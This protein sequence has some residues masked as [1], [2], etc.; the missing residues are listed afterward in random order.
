MWVAKA[1]K[2]AS[3]YRPTRARAREGDNSRRSRSFR[4]SCSVRHRPAGRQHL[5]ARS[6][7]RRRTW[8][9]PAA[10]LTRTT[11]E[12]TIM[13]GS[14]LRAG[15]SEARA[16]SAPVAA[17]AA[18]DPAGSAVLALDLGQKTGWAVRNAD[19]AIASGTV[20]F[21]PSRWE[22]GGMVYLRFRA[23][24][25]DDD[26]TAGGIGAVYFEE[27]G[28]PPRHCREPCLRWLP[29]SPDRLGRGRQDP[30]P[31]RA[32]RHDQEACDRPRQRRQDGGHRGGSGTRL[33]PSRRQRGGRA[34][35][36]RRALRN[37]GRR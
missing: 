15:R 18:G 7:W 19:S 23:G 34:G 33:R 2:V 25:Q 14:T 1:S 36:A 16:I 8:Q 30:V 4:A 10:I 24:L 3:C 37:G 29:G 35:A 5:P 12:G 11:L 28:R 27:V 31:R 21:K 20:E 6:G 17:L 26:E 22:G 32:G 13:A 9:D